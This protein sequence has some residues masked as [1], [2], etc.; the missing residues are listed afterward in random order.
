MRN[1]RYNFLHLPGEFH[2]QH[3]TCEFL[4]Y[5]IEDFILKDEYKKLQTQTIDL[6]SELDLSHGENILSYLSRKGKSKEHNE[7]VT[8]HVINALIADICQF[9]QIALFS[10][11][12]ERL[13]VTF[14][15]IRKPFVYDL[16]IILRLYLTEDFLE[17]FNTENYFDTAKLSKEEL[18][19]LINASENM[20]FTKSIKASDV[21]DFIFEYSNS[22]SLINMSNKALHPS[23]TRNK[24]NKTEIQNINFVFST[25]ENHKSQWDYIYRRLP[26]LLLYLN[27]ILECVIFNHLEIDD[28]IYIARLTERA[29][30]LENNKK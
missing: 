22:D 25:K 18:I 17:K 30:F 16:I 19:E 3:K 29:K 2:K 27:E 13:T 4:L 11:L 5:Q 15:L 12:Q 8:S 14:S 9:L 28:E 24:N 6:E 26:F 7:I 10:S 1:E 23:T 21:Y 20:L